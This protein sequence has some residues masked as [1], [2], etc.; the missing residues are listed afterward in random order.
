MKSEEIMKTAIRT[1]KRATKKPAAKAKPA[2]KL[3]LYAK[4]S[5]EYATSPT[6]ALVTVGP[7][8]Y[9]SISG[10]GAPGGAAF[11]EAIG[12]LYGVAFTVKMTRKFAGKGDYVV[13]KLEGLWPDC[14]QGEPMPP[15]VEWTWQMLIRTPD[16]IR[17]EDI[18]QA[19]AVLNKRGKGAS[20]DRVQLVSIEEGQCVQ[21]LHIGPYE[22]EGTTMGAMK[23][24]AESKGL[25]FRGAHHEIYLSDPRRVVPAKLKT[26]LRHPVQ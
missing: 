7:A 19:V 2:E 12:A 18:T 24:F 4:Y 8:K 20:A 16:F 3:D 22:D 23:A 21:S 11:T 10:K 15:K 26:I 14:R 25:K 13:S 1:G 9:L 6:P 17:Q 5:K